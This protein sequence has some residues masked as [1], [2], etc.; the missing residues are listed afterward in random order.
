[1]QETRVLSLIWEDPTCH[2]EAQRSLC[3]TTTEPVLSSQG[4][5]LLKPEHSRARAGQQEKP[6]QWEAHAPT[7]E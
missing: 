3:A 1:M 5:E 7:R 6:P 2:G 4:A